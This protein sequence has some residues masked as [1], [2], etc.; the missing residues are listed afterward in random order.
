M[1]SGKRAERHLQSAIE[2]LSVLSRRN[3]RRVLLSSDSGL[4]FVSPLLASFL[5]VADTNAG[6][7]TNVLLFFMLFHSLACLVLM[8]VT[9]TY[10]TT[11]RFSGVNLILPIAAASIFA[12]VVPVLVFVLLDI[13]NAA[14]LRIGVISS[15]LTC[16]LL[17]GSR[18]LFRDL[19][20]RLIEKPTSKSIAIIYGA[21]EAGRQ[22][23]QSQSRNGEYQIVA[24]IDDNPA[25]L[26]SSIFNVP[27]LRADALPV[28]IAKWR[29][30]VVLLAMPGTNQEDRRSIIQELMHYDVRVKTMPRITDLLTG[31]AEVNKVADITLDDLLG[32]EQVSATPELMRCHLDGQT[33]LITGAGGSIGSE[34]SRHVVKWGAV[35]LVLVDQNEFALYAIDKEIRSLPSLQADIVTVLG[36]AKDHKAM[37]SVIEKYK[38]NTIYH[39]AA[40][41]H[42]PLLEGNVAPCLRNN[43]IG[44]SNIAELSG[45]LGVDQFVLVS[46]DKA[47]RP[48]NV[49]GA[50]KRV[51]EILVQNSAG[52]YQTTHYAIVRFGNVLG[53]SG[54]V[55]PRFK[56]QLSQGGPLTVTHPNATRYFMTIPE[57][58]ELVIQAGAL[59]DS[60]D[61]CLLDMGKPVP[62]LEL[63]QN[64]IRLAG[65]TPTVL[66]GD[67]NNKMRKSDIAI[68]ITGLRAGEKLVEELLI[69]DTP[70]ETAHPRIFKATEAIESAVATSEILRLAEIAAESNEKIDIEHLFSVTKVEYTPA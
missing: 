21:G 17:L 46:T 30:E 33:V 40:Y 66:E 60:G 41:K 18:V 36:D 43:V 54:S 37:K 47:V 67:E 42:V 7:P 64:M 28:A 38:V 70:E 9:S 20:A 6:L 25:L 29:V 57:A 14:L 22:L 69:S 32:R 49:M 35:C 65:Y 16:F 2:A 51:A 26:G 19:F 12:S 63:A 34:L 48:T 1:V 4:S 11:I 23:L 27:V 68:K 44:T 45:E 52:K 8:S 3:K 62:I 59:A 5:V 56:E 31:A 39:A 55:I 13:D 61:V 15:M 24:F 58:A 53:S 50:S 10:A